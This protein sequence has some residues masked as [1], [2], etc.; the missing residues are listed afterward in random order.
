M[1]RFK[2]IYG[3]LA[4]VAFMVAVAALTWQQQ[5]PK[6]AP[7]QRIVC[8]DIV[9]GCT[10]ETTHGPVHL[11]VSETIR[12]LHAFEIWVKPPRPGKVEAEFSMIDMNMGYNLY[13]LRPS[14]DGSYRIK[15]T[16]PFCISGRANW[17]LTLRLP[18]ATIEVPFNTAAPD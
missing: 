13:T 1:T 11:G 17:I 7:A 15:A 8:A 18:D 6:K 4:L 16:L 2:P 10:A 14:P 3:K 5:S 9:A 12:P